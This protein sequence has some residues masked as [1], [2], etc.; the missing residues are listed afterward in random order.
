MAIVP[1]YIPPPP[2]HSGGSIGI[3]DPVIIA[4]SWAVALSTWAITVIFLKMLFDG[5]RNKW[6]IIIGFSFGGIIVLLGSIL[7]IVIYL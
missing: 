2:I 4:I 6:D 3:H 1:Y 5:Y 7:L